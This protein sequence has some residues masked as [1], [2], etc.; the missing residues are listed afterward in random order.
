MIYIPFAFISF[1]LTCYD[2]DMKYNEYLLPFENSDS[3]VRC[4]CESE[5]VT[6]RCRGF[7]SGGGWERWCKHIWHHRSQSN[8]RRRASVG[9]P[10]L[11][12]S[13]LWLK[14]WAAFFSLSLSLLSSSLILF[15]SPL[16]RHSSTLSHSLARFRLCV[17]PPLVIGGQCVYVYV[18]VLI[19][20]VCVV[21][22][23]CLSV[24]FIVYLCIM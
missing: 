7:L 22:D 14:S 23:M 11:S 13:P 15:L 9:F 20:S 6:Y 21:C 3:I 5:T 18:F 4:S 2:L 16:L 24:W 1:I 19:F 17:R 8:R 12:P 10:G